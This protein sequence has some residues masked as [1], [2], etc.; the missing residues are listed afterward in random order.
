MISFHTNYAFSDELDFKLFTS[1]EPKLI[2][3]GCFD[4]FWSSYNGSAKYFIFGWDAVPDYIE[5][6][7]QSFNDSFKNIKIKIV[8]ISPIT[9]G[10]R[11]VYVQENNNNA[12]SILLTIELNNK[13]E[14]KKYLYYG[15]HCLFRLLSLSE[16]VYSKSIPCDRKKVMNTTERDFCSLVSEVNNYWLGVN[17]CYRGIEYAFSPENVLLLDDIELCNKVFLAFHNR[18]YKQTDIMFSLYYHSNI[19]VKYKMESMRE[20]IKKELGC[21]KDDE[22]VS[23]YPT[24]FG[25]IKGFKTQSTEIDDYEYQKRMVSSYYNP[26]K[27]AMIVIKGKGGL[28]FKRMEDVYVIKDNKIF[29]TNKLKY[30]ICC[31]CR[32][33]ITY[34]DLHIHYGLCNACAEKISSEGK[35]IKRMCTKHFMHPCRCNYE[36][37]FK[38]MTPKE[39]ETRFLESLKLDGVIY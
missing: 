15:I 16:E 25:I 37:M 19:F 33:H 26:V 9:F 13:Y 30:S 36:T 31:S 32:T 20:L 14:Y 4:Q 22:V 8:A 39:F 1:V 23:F 11:S 35:G 6:V 34:L 17:Y 29:N 10:D 2:R 5:E 18:T 28:F 21:E 27:S 12:K 24:K 38:Y 3:A 7:I